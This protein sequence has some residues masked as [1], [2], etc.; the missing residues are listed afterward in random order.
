MATPAAAITLPYGPTGYHPNPGS[1][2]TPAPDAVRGHWFYPEDSRQRHEEGMVALKISLTGD[3]AMREAV[4]E[5]SSGFPR[6]DEAALQYARQ[7]YRYSL[8]EGEKMPEIA[9]ITVKFDLD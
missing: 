5:K 3:G 7:S 8:D 1:H 9:R 4:I 2:V 6:L